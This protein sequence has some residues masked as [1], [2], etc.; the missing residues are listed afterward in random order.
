[1]AYTLRATREIRHGRRLAAE[2]TERV[3]G[4]GTPAGGLRAAR[5]AGLIAGGARLG[6]GV[7]ALEIGCGTGLFTEFFARTGAFIVAVDISED[8]LRKARRRGL[9]GDRVHFMRG[10]FEDCAV[11]GPFDAVIGSSVLHHLEVE[12][13]LRKAFELLRPGGRLSFA[14]PN[15]LNPQICLERRIKW[16]RAFFPYVSADETAFVRGGLQRLLE[17][18]GFAGVR[19]TPFDFLHPATPRAMIGAVRRLGRGLEAVPGI[20]ELAGSLHIEGERPRG[21][22]GRG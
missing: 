9:P 5:R 18:V 2:D 12:P 16:L 10:R 3:W 20:R 1:M 14:E 11:E 15:M 13:S 4:W 7:R 21:R 17:R 6:P 19:I 8:L 22:G